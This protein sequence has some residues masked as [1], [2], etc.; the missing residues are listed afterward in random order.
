M[1]LSHLMVRFITD[2]LLLG[3]GGLLIWVAIK[4]WRTHPV[5]R[6]FS[7][8][9]YVTEEGMRL[10]LQHWMVVFSFGLTLVSQGLSR[11]AFKLWKLKYIGTDLEIMLGITEVCFT[12][13]AA[14]CFAKAAIVIYRRNQ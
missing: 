12:A 1:P 8:G 3:I 5:N 9:P 4:M 6:V 7:F 13:W 11:A 14:Y 10:V 2:L